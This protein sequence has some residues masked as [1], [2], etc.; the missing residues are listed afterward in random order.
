MLMYDL[1]PRAFN[2]R[3]RKLLKIDKDFIEI[4]LREIDAAL[5]RCT[6]STDGPDET[7]SK[8][9]FMILVGLVLRHGIE[10]GAIANRLGITVSTVHRWAR[11]TFVPPQ[12][13]V[14][15]AALRGMS[16]L[17]RREANK[18]LSVESTARNVGE[19]DE[20]PNGMSPRIDVDARRSR[21]GS[22]DTV[23]QLP[24]T[25]TSRGNRRRRSAAGS[26]AVDKVG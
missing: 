19:D 9:E 15:E 10:A 17:L 20:V 7:A 16:E 26:G 14:R 24:S 22:V 8:D 2:D 1:G 4:I 18:T 11:G 23:V 6:T 5:Q 21:R 3:N 13:F 25:I 12:Q